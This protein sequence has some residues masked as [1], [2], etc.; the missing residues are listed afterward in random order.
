M[1]FEEMEDLEIPFE[2]VLTRTRYFRVMF[3]N[4]YDATKLLSYY[5][6]QDMLTGYVNQDDVTY[7]LIERGTITPEESEFIEEIR[8]LTAHEYKQAMKRCIKIV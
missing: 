2:S 4:R 5:L 1:N 7:E 6:V 8:E 3:G